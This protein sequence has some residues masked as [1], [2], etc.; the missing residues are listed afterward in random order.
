M[1]RISRS[2]P[3]LPDARR[4][5]EVVAAGEEVR[6]PERG[7]A[8]PVPQAQDRH[9]REMGAGR[10]A[11]DEQARGAEAAL[12]FPDHPQSRRL[13][14]VGCS[15]IGMLRGQTILDGD[16]R[17]AAPFCKAVEPGILL[18]RRTPGPAAA[19]DME[20]DAARGLRRDDPQRDGSGRPVDGDGLRPGAQG[21]QGERP[22][23][24]APPLAHQ[25]R[26][27]RHRVRQSRELGHDI[28]IL[29]ADLVADGGRVEEGGI[30][31]A[32]LGVVAFVAGACDEAHAK[33]QVQLRF[34]TRSRIMSNLNRFLGG[35]P[36]SVLVK[37]I[38][39]S[40]LVGAFLAFLGI[41]PFGLIEGLFNWISSVLDLSFETVQ[42]VGLWVLYGAIIVV[43][44]W[45]ISRLFSSR[46]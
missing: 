19:M 7:E 38:F 35:S 4:Q 2:T 13:A 23:P 21:H 39:L 8:V 44:L 43:P 14:I 46:R 18:V 12:H 22:E 17:E 20:I 40:L 29:G 30:D 42:E 37:L 6:A 26:R 11:A 32:S 16:H 27:H 10:L 3:Q 1:L 25:S 34:L 45:L 33:P 28:G 15:R 36:G 31:H 41:T 24:L 5:G 9:R